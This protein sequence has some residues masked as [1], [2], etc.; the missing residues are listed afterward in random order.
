[1]KKVW[2]A[3]L[4]GALL[5][6]PFGAMAMDS[7]T[8]LEDPARYRVIY[9]DEEETVY[10]D[11]DTVQSMATRDYPGSIENMSFT[12]YVE[13]YAKNPD[14]MD[15]EAGKLVTTVQKYQ[16]KLYGNKAKDQYKMETSLAAVYDPA[17]KRIG[18]A[19]W[20]GPKTDAEADDLYYTLYR[21]IRVAH[22]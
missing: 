21:L 7:N 5:A 14:A 8:L 19:D 4:A 18:N 13:T 22:R 10:A 6:A 11:M 2:A 17:G 16:T 12:M 20:K 3:A 1:M 15:F 9:A